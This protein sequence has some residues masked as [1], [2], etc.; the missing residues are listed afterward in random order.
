MQFSVFFCYIDFHGLKQLN[1]DLKHNLLLSHTT[2]NPEQNF[3]P[4]E[5]NLLDFFGPPGVIKRGTHC[6]YRKASELGV[7]AG[8]EML[9]RCQLLNCE[10]EK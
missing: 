1:Q 2:C 5:G 4:A 3:C 8:S 6:L 10:A 7:W 9:C